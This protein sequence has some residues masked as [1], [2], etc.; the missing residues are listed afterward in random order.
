MVIDKKLDIAV[1]ATPADFPFHSILTP[2]YVR[3]ALEKVKMTKPTA[4][5]S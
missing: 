3:N 5:P 1:H 2:K 4:L